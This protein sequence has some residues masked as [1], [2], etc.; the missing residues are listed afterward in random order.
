MALNIREVTEPNHWAFTFIRFIVG[1]EEVDYFGSNVE[2][3]GINF[4]LWVSLPPLINSSSKLSLVSFGHSKHFFLSF[5][6]HNKPIK[7]VWL[8]LYLTEEETGLWEGQGT[9]PWRTDLNSSLSD[10]KA[11]TFKP[12]GVPTSWFSVI[13]RTPG[14]V[15]ELRLC[16]PQ[17]GFCQCF[18]LICFQNSAH[19]CLLF[20]QQCWFTFP[21]IN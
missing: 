11:Q 10:T 17:F 12:A 3:L 13:A 16:A 4:D 6:F 2:C 7:W 19:W 5:S 14:P 20:P 21:Q 9:P 8:L 15:W 1:S 18:C